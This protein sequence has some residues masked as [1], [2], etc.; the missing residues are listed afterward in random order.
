MYTAS[1]NPTSTSS[2]QDSLLRALARA[3]A[4]LPVHLLLEGMRHGR[5]GGIVEMTL[6]AH[7]AYWQTVG[8]RRRNTDRGMPSHIKRHSIAQHVPAMRNEF[9]DPKLWPI[10]MGFHGSRGHGEDTNMLEDCIIARP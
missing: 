1:R 2:D 10:C 7:E 8:L 3:S 5:H 4:F 9:L 6:G